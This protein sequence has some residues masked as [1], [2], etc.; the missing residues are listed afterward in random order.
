MRILLALPALL[1]CESAG[2]TTEPADLAGTWTAESFVFTSVADPTVSSDLIAQGGSAT[3]TITAQGG[4]TLTTEL[5]GSTD[6]DTGTLTVDGELLTMEFGGDLASGTIHRDGD[7]LTILLTT[8]VEFDVDGDGSDE[9]ATFR[10]V[11][12]R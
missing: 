5:M 8:G 4:T 2:I 9:A 3:L 7:R 6:S 1:A 10:G 11:F 12:R